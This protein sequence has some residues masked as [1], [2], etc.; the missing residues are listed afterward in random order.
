MKRITALLVLL[1]I[2][3]S[4]NP[5]S[6]VKTLSILETLKKEEEEQ[7]SKG[8]KKPG[9]KELSGFKKPSINGY[10]Y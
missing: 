1:I 3:I 7:I 10:I 2:F 9:K 6:E 4:C 8:I 5:K